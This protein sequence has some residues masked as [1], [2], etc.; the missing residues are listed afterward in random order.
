MIYAFSYIYEVGR[1][2]IRPDV[3]SFCVNGNYNFRIIYLKRGIFQSD[4]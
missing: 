2:V 1:I 4:F 3:I